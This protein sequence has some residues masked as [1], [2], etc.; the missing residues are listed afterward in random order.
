MKKFIIFCLILVFPLSTNALTFNPGYIISD[1]D[2]T[3]YQSMDQ[4]E[5]QSFLEKKSGLLDNYSC[6]DTDGITK[7]ASEIIYNSALLNKVNPKFLLV[8]LQKE[9]SL[10]EDST[11]RQSQYD[12]AMGYAVCDSCSMDDP[13]IQKFKGFGNQVDEAA[14]A[15]RWYSENAGNG[16]AKAAGESYIID[17]ELITMANQATA[18]LYTFTPHIHGNYN[19]WKIWQQWFTQNYP[20]GSLLSAEGESGVFLIENATK[21]PFITYGALLSRFDASLI[22]KASKADLDSYEDGAPIKYANYSLLE[23]KMGNKFLLVDSALRKFESEEVVRAIGY[24]PDEFE[25]IEMSEF[26]LFEKGEDLTV[27]SIYPAGALLQDNE[28]GAVF[29]IQDAVKYP[30][31]SKDLL[32]INFSSYSIIPVHPEELEKYEQGALVKPREGSLLMVPNDPAVY[33]ISQGKRWPII[34]EDVFEELGYDWK[35]VKTVSAATLSHVPIG[36]FIE[37]SY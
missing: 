3:D 19:F 32:L 12:W 20:D 27:G 4:G 10:I 30:V 34:S 18:N 22:I 5:I 17:D 24:H 37:V 1:S 26:K 35:N 16:I 28:T 29:F 31:P 33:V 14:G 8:M 13:K 2:L 36:N 11:P 7:S 6:K 21:R 23:S 9:Q 25:L 15:Q